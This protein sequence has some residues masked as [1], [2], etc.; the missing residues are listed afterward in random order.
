[1]NKIIPSY[2][3]QPE[4]DFS[5]HDDT[6]VTSLQS[7]LPDV[8]QN[9]FKVQCNSKSCAGCSKIQIEDNGNKIDMKSITNMTPEQ[10]DF[11]HV[12]K[13]WIISLFILLKN[14][15]KMASLTSILQELTILFASHVN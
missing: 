10:L 13:Q 11:L 2:N 7:I 1:M 9:K 3:L 15:L 4:L 8:T 5:D 6:I 12:H 14:M